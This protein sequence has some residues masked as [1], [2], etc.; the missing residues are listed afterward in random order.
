MDEAQ[1]ILDIPAISYAE[2]ERQ[3]R[4]RAAQRELPAG[5]SGRSTPK[6][7]RM[8]REA[9]I[10]PQI[11]EAVNAKL[12]EGGLNR[13]QAFAAV[14][15]ERGMRPGTVA[16]NYYR[17]V[18]KQNPSALKSTRR[19][20]AAGA[21]RTTG[22]AAAKKPARAARRTRRS[23]APAA[24][25]A[26]AASTD[27]QAIA[28]QLVRNVEALAAAVTAQSKELQELRSRLDGVRSLLG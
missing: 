26:A 13:S 1:P 23:A 18:R 20:R 14:A 17:V 9:V 22:R 6:E 4:E 15:A 10:G 5:T 25:A 28:A 3:Q 12:A 2:V 11:V 27:V 21:S 19:T 24:P 7:Q 16:A 8:P